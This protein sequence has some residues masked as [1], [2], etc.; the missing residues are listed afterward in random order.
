MSHY[1]HPEIRLLLIDQSDQT[2]QMLYSDN[3]STWAMPLIG[4]RPPFYTNPRYTQ[5][6]PI[7]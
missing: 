5:T 7:L 1:F 3:A 6:F 2:V 4:K